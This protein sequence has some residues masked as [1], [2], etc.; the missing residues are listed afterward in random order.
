MSP[1]STWPATSAPTPSRARQF[2]RNSV[3]GTVAGFLIALGSV[4]ANVIVAQCLGV[5]STGVVAFALA[6]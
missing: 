3:F 2:A 5:E 1:P 4:A 6:R